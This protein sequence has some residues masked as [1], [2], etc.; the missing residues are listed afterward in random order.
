MTAYELMIKTNHHLIQGGDFNDAQK[1]NIVNQL[2]AAQCTPE[3]ARR[4]HRGMRN[5]SNADGMYPVFYIP[6]YIGG[7]KHET[8]I[9]MSPQTHILS[10]NSY[11]LEILRLLYILAPDHEQVRYMIAQ[12]LE[13]LKK[14]CFGW[15]CCT[16]GECFESGLIVLRFII[17]VVPSE[18]TWIKRQM[19]IYDR[20]HKIKK[21]NPGVAEY[22]ALCLSEL[23]KEFNQ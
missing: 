18:T 7:T 3:A 12:T 9:P 22:Y 6:P 14:T 8:V 5:A 23:P 16:T 17:A 4:F 10:A 13:R 11:E 1:A 15:K 21:R 19:Q 2:L 20:Y